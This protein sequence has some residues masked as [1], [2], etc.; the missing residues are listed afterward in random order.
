MRR[1]MLTLAVPALAVIA[2]GCGSS[3]PKS[4][5]TARSAAKTPPAKAVVAS[6]VKVQARKLPK[7]GEVLVSASGRTLYVFAPDKASRVSCTASCQS[8]WPPLAAPSSGRAEAIGPV[9]STLIGSDPNPVG[10]RVV[11]YNGWPLYTFVG[12]SAP[13]TANG[14]RKLLN[15]GTWYVMS[16]SGKPV[17]MSGGGSSTGSSSSGYSSGY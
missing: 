12:D 7:L 8:V 11:T 5:T 17:G 6:G 13:G 16:T 1:S 15:G 9:K 10:G 3:A 4:H 2:A 14:Q